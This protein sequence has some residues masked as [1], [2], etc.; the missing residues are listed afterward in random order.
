V[1]VGGAV[2]GLGRLPRGISIS[3]KYYIPIVDSRW[4]WALTTSVST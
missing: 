1:K 2:L 3:R 4:M